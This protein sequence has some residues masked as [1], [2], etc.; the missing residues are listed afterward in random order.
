MTKTSLS[1]DIQGI[2]KPIGKRLEHSKKIECSF[3]T[4][5]L[6]PIT[7]ITI[8][9]YSNGEFVKNVGE[10]DFIGKNFQPIS[11]EVNMCCNTKEFEKLIFKGI[12]ILENN[13]ML[14]LNIQ[15]YTIQQIISLDKFLE[16]LNC[17]YSA[18]DRSSDLDPCTS[19]AYYAKM[20]G[21]RII[22]AKDKYPEILKILKSLEKELE[23]WLEK[24]NQK[25]KDG[26]T[27][28][29]PELD[30]RDSKKAELELLKN[31]LQD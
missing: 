25:I 21:Y 16:T 3:G 11:K 23:E 30:K 20:L 2:S 18:M 19:E 9:I 24:F 4:F 27:I 17:A 13:K 15:D 12:A 14:I 1:S 6:Y 10:V 22:D 8:A 5:T 31:I 29:L 26:K 28:T 7:D